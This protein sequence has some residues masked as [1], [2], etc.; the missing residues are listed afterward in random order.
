MQILNLT[1]NI[2]FAYFSVLNSKPRNVVG[3]GLKHSS[4]EK[5]NLICHW[6]WR[7]V[8]LLTHKHTHSSPYPSEPCR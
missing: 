1:A 4:I 3:I 7:E 8:V 5:Q 6:V 2:L